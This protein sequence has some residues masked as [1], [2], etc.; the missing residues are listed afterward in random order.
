L[1][2]LKYVG[3]DI[4]IVMFIVSESGTGWIDPGRPPVGKGPVRFTAKHQVDVRYKSSKN[5]SAGQGRGSCRAKAAAP[6]T[7]MWFGLVMYQS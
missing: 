2:F 7:I 6:A 4:Y 1:H 3:N 5:E